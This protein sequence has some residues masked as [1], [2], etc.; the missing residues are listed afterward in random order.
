MTSKIDE[1]I[2]EDKIEKV[3]TTI[4][5]NKDLYDFGVRFGKKRNI[6][7]SKVINV[8]LKVHSDWFEEQIKKKEDKQE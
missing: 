4:I 1:A 7:F 2:K 5:V 3:R 8:L 6:S